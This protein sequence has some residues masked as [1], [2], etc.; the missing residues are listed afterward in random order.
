MQRIG[1]VIGIRPEGVAKYIDLHR[2]VPTE[3]VEHIRRC[4]Y[5]NY[6]I[7]HW[8]EYLFAYIE[9]VGSDFAADN[10]KMADH[11]PTQQWW[12]R[13]GPL[14]SPV[15]SR[16]EGEWWHSIAEIYHQD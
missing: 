3:V 16:K 4:N 15:E 14:Q 7:F 6:S 8:G 12:Q 1:Q 11:G 9:Y 2:E 10:R 13:V 5:Q